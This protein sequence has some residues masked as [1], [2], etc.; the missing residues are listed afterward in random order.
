MSKEKDA[1]I[2]GYSNS[3]SRSV[4]VDMQ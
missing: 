3:Y 2:M 1:R 4:P